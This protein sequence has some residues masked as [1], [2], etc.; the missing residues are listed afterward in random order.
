MES[1]LQIVEKPEWVSWDE[2][3]EV[4]WKAH[5]QNRKKG[6]IM[7]YPS[8]S[9]E[10]IRNKIGDK[11]KMFVAIEDDKVI[12]TLAL[13]KKVGKQWYN[14]GQYGYLCFGAVLPECSGKGVYRSLYQLAETT[15]KQMGLLVLTR[16]TNENNARMLKITKQEGY[17]FVECKAWKDHFNIVRAKW[18]DKCPYPTWYIKTRFLLSKMII[19]LRYRMDPLKGKVKRFGK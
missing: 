3:H 1:E 16:D 6:I 4:L 18:L 10:E 12:G 11:G 9:G 14:T 15:A 5:E 19:K 17:H 2:I 7:S 13:I 8:L